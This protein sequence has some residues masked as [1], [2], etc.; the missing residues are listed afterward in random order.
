ML[1]A[2]ACSRLCVGVCLLSRVYVLLTNGVPS[3]SIASSMSRGESRPG[4]S[5]FSNIPS[6]RQ[7]LLLHPL[8]GVCGKAAAK[9]P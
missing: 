6:A 7:K 5:H 8:F 2:P 4:G 9:A 1:F 3:L